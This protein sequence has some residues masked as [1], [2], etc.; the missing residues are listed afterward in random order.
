MV[1]G[2]V[3][4]GALLYLYATR[5]LTTAFVHSKLRVMSTAEF[6]LPA[7]AICTLAVAGAVAL[8][9]AIRLLFFSHRI[10]GPLYR[11]EQTAQA[12][13]N[14]DLNAEVRL[15]GGDELQDFARSMGGMVSDLR[16]RVQQIREQTQ[17]L[18]EILAQ[19]NHR[20]AMPPELLRQLQDT[21]GR[22][23]DAISRFRV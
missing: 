10:A 22:L 17:R 8:V 18:Q 12:I 2:C 15:R 23:N 7:L 19:A 9:A 5:T 13:G 1:L 6:L 16:A 20:A 21:Q 4:F 14:G 3:A 11:L